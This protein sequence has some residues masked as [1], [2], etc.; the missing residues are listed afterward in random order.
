MEIVSNNDEFACNDAILTS[1]GSIATSTCLY[2]GQ[3]AN[4]TNNYSIYS[5][6]WSEHT[7]MAQ[8]KLQISHPKVLV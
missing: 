7:L 5:S 8:C 6:V 3:M 1:G 4:A 2:I